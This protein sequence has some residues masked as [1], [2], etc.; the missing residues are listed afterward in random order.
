MQNKTIVNKA[1]TMEVKVGR[2]SQLRLPV[3]NF[4]LEDLLVVR[5]EQLYVL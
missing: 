3:A 1:R 2:V 4:D 5:A